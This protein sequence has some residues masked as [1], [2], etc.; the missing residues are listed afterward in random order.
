MTLT[1]IWILKKMYELEKDHWY[2]A[3]FVNTLLQEIEELRLFISEC[4]PERWIRENNV[5]KAQQWEEEA[6][7]KILGK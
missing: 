4:A 3:S 7:K 1:T 2:N 5:E 6:T